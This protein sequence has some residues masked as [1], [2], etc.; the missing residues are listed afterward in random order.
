MKK[1]KKINNIVKAMN[2][3]KGRFFGLKTRQGENLNAKFIR[4]TPEYVLVRDRNSNR[5]RKFA[6]TSLKSFSMGNVQV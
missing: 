4:E 2:E 6:K 3:S 5:V 1:N